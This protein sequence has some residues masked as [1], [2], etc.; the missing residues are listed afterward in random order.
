MLIHSFVKKLA[1]SLPPVSCAPVQISYDFS[2]YGFFFLLSRLFLSII[3]VTTPLPLLYRK[4]IFHDGVH[5]R[6]LCP[7]GDGAAGLPWAGVLYPPARS[8]RSGGHLREVFGG[9]HENAGEGGA[10]G[11]TAGE[12]RRLSPVPARRRD[13]RRR[14][15]ADHGGL[16]GPGDLSV[17]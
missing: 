13:H 10:C 4:E 5:Q 15:A 14:R 2:G 12:G 6:P 8:G 9:H 3:A 7:S 17:P 1:A 11:G 16:L